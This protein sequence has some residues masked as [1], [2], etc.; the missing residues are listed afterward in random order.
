MSCIQQGGI[1][2]ELREEI[3][4]KLVERASPLFGKKPE[5]L[6]E[7]LSFTSDLQAKSVHFSQITTFLEDAFNVE[8]PYMKFRR[9][10][11]IAEAVDYVLEICENG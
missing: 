4:A 8:I 5:D 3:Y 7:S 11:T 2:L 1:V 10:Q 9:K 6:S